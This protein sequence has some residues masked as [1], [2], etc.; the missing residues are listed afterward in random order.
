LFF[1]EIYPQ[2][3]ISGVLF[4]GLLALVALGLTLIFGVSGVLNIAHGEFLM[5][6]AVAAYWLFNVFGVN[7]FTAL[8]VIGPL[9]LIAGIGLNSLLAKPMSAKSADVVL[10]SSILVTLGLS[11]VI[12]DSAKYSM[13]TLL[14]IAHFPIDYSLGPFIIGSL[15]IPAIRL[16]SLAV[17]VAVTIGLRVFIT[18]TRTGKLMRAVMQDREVAVMLGANPRRLT[19]VSFAIGTMA[20]AIAGVFL[21]LIQ[22]MDYFSGLPLTVDALTV[23]ILGGLGSFP[24]ALVGGLIVGIA[25]QYTAFFTTATWAPVAPLVILVLALIL[26]PQGLFRGRT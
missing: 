15:R 16:A 21:H 3:L 6:G 8:I 17:V 13:A 7:P 25:R 22:Q 5:L 4:G 23:V 9:F 1:P 11:S 18:R 24:G 19:L 12:S 14:G 26:R 10:A 2:I 20:A